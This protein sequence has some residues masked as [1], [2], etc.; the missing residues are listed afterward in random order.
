MKA[1]LCRAYGP[2]STLVMD[3]APDPHA[4]PGQIVIDVHAAGVNFPDVLLIQG[5]YQVKPPLP[6]SPGVEVAGVVS[7]VGEGLR[8]AL[9]RRR[10]IGGVDLDQRELA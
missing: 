10:V 8:G 5:L 2:P 9:R 1:I 6:F 3:E 7:E 4:G